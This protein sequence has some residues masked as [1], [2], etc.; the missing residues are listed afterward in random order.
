MT[1]FEVTEP[2]AA[3]LRGAETLKADPESNRVFLRNGD[4]YKAGETFKQPD[5]ASTLERISNHG[6]EGFYEGETAAQISTAM[7]QHGG[8]ITAQDL[9][10][11][12]VAERAPLTGDYKGFH[13]ITAPPP[14]AGGVGLLQMMEM[15]EGTGY[16]SGG[17]GFRQSR[18]L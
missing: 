4:P 18:S 17:T 16:N 5:L 12:K 7:A 8:L 13:I 2:F 3:S 10:S 1:D 15:L 11:Y 9:K 6:A 14:S